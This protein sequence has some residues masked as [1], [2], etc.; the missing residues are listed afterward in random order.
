MWP[1]ALVKTSS[2]FRGN[3]I[4]TTHT[5]AILEGITRDALLTICRDLGFELK[6]QPISRDQ[7]YIADELFVCGTAAECIGVSEVDF[8][9]IGSGKTGPMTKKIQT[10]FHETLRGKGK[11]SA[12]WLAYVN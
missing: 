7:L 11:H 4:Y 3:T 5:A 10:V 12:E 2:S 9:V 8:R 6:E 1:N